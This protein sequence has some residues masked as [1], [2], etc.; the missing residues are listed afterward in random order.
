MKTD[1]RQSFIA[2]SET[3][4]AFEWK[5]G[6][7]FCLKIPQGEQERVQKPDIGSYYG[8]IPAFPALTRKMIY[9][10]P[11]TLCFTLI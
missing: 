10:L 1:I 11:I 4:E 3:S 7:L 8:N 2:E 6:F 9:S 5:S